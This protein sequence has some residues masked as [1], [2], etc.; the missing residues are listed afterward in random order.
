MGICGCSGSLVRDHNAYLN[1]NKSADL[2]A[3]FPQSV[4]SAQK[5]SIPETWKKAGTMKDLFKE[6]GLEENV[7]GWQEKQED[8]IKFQLIGWTENESLSLEERQTGKN[9][10]SQSDFL[11]TRVS[12]SQMVLTQLWDVN[13]AIKSR[14]TVQSL[15]S[16]DFEKI[17][18]NQIRY[19]LFGILPQENLDTISLTYGPEESWN[20]D[21]EASSGSFWIKDLLLDDQGRPFSYVLTVW[22]KNKAEPVIEQTSDTETIQI[23]VYPGCTEFSRMQSLNHSLEQV[24]S[25]AEKLSEQDEH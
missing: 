10:K 9:G 4:K 13:G 14:K 23:K 7:V 19:I 8:T 15:S 18:Q 2:G 6:I 21:S 16:P 3:L 17:G 24:A 1:P 20:Y 12:G 22:R 25:R 5:K 11:S